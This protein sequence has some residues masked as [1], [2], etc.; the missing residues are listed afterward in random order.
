MLMRV[1][2]T[3]YILNEHEDLDNMAHMQYHPRQY[4]VK[5]I[6]PIW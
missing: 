4:H 2:D 5:A 3:N 6:L 1:V